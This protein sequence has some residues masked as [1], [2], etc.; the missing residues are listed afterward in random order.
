M[1]E[2]RTYARIDVSKFQSNL[3][4]VRELAGDGCKLLQVLKA[5]AYGHG[6]SACA[7][8]AAPMVDYFAV[9][10][11]EEAL[12]ARMEAPHTP[13]LLFG[14]LQPF[15]VE[16]AAKADITVNLFSVQYAAS[17]S[18]KL[19][20]LGK[21]IKGHIKFDTGMNR[22]GIRTRLERMDEAVDEAK[23][24]FAMPNLQVTGCY[25]HFACAD[26]RDGSDCAFTEKQFLAFSQVTDILRN[27]GYK[28]GLRHC[29][30]TG[31]F[32]CH[33]EYKMDMIRTGMLAYGQGLSRD[34]VMEM[35]IDPILTW[36]ARII[37]VRVLEKGESIS[38]GRIYTAS[39]DETIAVIGAGYA[40]GYS[41]AFSNKSH[42][43]I[44][45]M[46]C[47]V[48]GK[49]CMDYTMVDV[50]NCEKVKPGDWAILL[51]KDDKQWIAAD[52]LAALVPLNTNGG[53]TS[54]INDRVPRIYFEE[55]NIVC[56]RFKQYRT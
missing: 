28:I 8:Y 20:M 50:S 6:V 32:I 44:D 19:G 23:K 27:D 26:T 9:A 30:S 22:L 18:E 12:A 3:K 55:D 14:A 7:K 52:D 13:I 38:Y 10:T 54:E 43:I 24:I 33:P 1:V 34:N 16:T 4:K 11:L 51:G 40:D 39:Q 41:R 17:L 56:E 35:G 25:T 29:V 53:V 5:D 46:L 37:D 42:V 48:R 21:R 47:P 36:F 31:G 49:I 45:G 2:Y 15:E